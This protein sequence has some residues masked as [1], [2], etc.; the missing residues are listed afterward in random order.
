MYDQQATQQQ[1]IDEEVK[2]NYGRKGF[3]KEV[4][5]PAWNTFDEQEK[6]IKGKSYSTT[7]KFLFREINLFIPEVIGIAVG[8]LGAMLLGFFGL[9]TNS[10]ILVLCAGAIPLIILIA[11]FFV[12]MVIFMPN[13]HRHLTQRILPSGQIRFSVDEVKTNEIPFDR[14][15][16]SPKIRITNPKKNTDFNTGRP[17]ITLKAGNGEN[18]D[19]ARSENTSQQAV[20]FDN[21]CIT[22]IGVQKAWDEYNIAAPKKNMEIVLFIMCAIAIVA[23]L[24]AAYMG[25]QNQDM[26]TQLLASS[27]Q[28]AT[29]VAAN[30]VTITTGVA[31]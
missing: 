22:S 11:F 9:I 5:A 13:K 30:G 29:N 1:R 25:Y 16:M 27:K 18:M 15:P 6:N 17:V 3:V 21:L 20:D 8:A 28:I 10:L 24:G 31:K 19:L 7:S 14:S 4:E 12:R 23:A 26:L 2:T